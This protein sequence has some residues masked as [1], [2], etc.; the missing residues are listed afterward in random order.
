MCYR[1]RFIYG[2]AEKGELG[3]SNVGG[4]GL[5]ISPRCVD[6][7][8][9]CSLPHPRVLDIF[10]HCHCYIYFFH[11]FLCPVIV[12]YFNTITKPG[13]NKY[14]LRQTTTQTTT[15]SMA[16]NQFFIIITK[17]CEIFVMLLSHLYVHQ[18]QVIILQLQNTATVQ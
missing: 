8:D 3:K 6:A 12:Q 15:M 5:L 16:M 1:V 18:V 2:S 14:I 7:Y 10:I 4:V 17:S 13:I 11:L 9:G